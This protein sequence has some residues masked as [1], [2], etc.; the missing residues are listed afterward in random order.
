[1]SARLSLLQAWLTPVAA[2]GIAVALVLVFW[3]APTERTMG[4]VQRIFYF[5]VPAAWSAFLCFFVVFAGSLGTLIGRRRGW[6]ILALAAAEVGVVF[7]TVVL[8]TGP[9]W[10][11]PAWGIWWTWDSRLTSTLVLWLTY[12]GYLMVRHYVSDAQRRASLAAVVGILGFLDVPI[13]YFSIRWWRTQHPKPV[14]AGGEGS[15]LH[16]D[17]ALTFFVC[18]AAVTLLTFALLA[19]RVRLERHRDR[20]HA[21]DLAISDREAD[22]S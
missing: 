13:V 8:V 20:A 7:C 1:M 12:L 19:Q 9:I 15:G 14:I 5:H 4:D 17:M 11:K 2:V 10:A 21:L 6:D 3:F 22:R 18:L 16:P